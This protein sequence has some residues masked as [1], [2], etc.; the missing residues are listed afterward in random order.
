VTAKTILVTGAAGGIGSSF[1]RSANGYRLRLT[2]RRPEQLHHLS[3]LGEIAVAD[4]T[5][6]HAVKGLCRDMDTVVHLAANPEPDATW[7]SLLADNIVATYNV[8]TAA[9]SAGCKK[10]IFASSIH[11]VS[12]Y[13][14]AR[15]VRSTD[16]VNPGTLYGV[17]KC[18]GEALGRYV[19][20]QEGLTVV[21][22]RFGAFRP[23][24]VAQDPDAISWLDTFISPEDAN[25]L[26]MLAIEAPVAGFV[27]AHGSSA[28]R[29]S[30]LDI[31]D[32]RE[33]LQYTPQDDLVAM[34]PAL[35]P[36]LSHSPPPHNL[37]DPTIRSGLRD[38][39]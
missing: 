26:L 10:V 20:E 34:H 17:S 23:R 33:Q 12:G 6:L 29:F 14:P 11:A 3:D 15:Q 36:I 37:S 7:P 18:F 25:M 24:E 8:F 9:V 22:I 1:A 28:N 35:G 31:T 13:L 21:A 16:P 32:T 30:R 38:D 39:V 27:L 2:D 19:A 5:D 4:L